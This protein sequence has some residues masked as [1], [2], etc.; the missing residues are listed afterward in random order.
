[1]LG[2]FRPKGRVEILITRNVLSQNCAAVY[3][4]IATFCP[5]YILTH[6]AARG[7]AHCT[8]AQAL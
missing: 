7:F 3:Q 1:M 4:Q 8:G 5:S 6:D 2:A